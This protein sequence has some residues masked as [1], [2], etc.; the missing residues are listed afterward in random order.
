MKNEASLQTR[1]PDQ[2]LFVYQ[3]LGEQN[4]RKDPWWLAWW[5]RL[6]TPPLLA[7]R[8]TFQ[9]RDIERRARIASA[10]SLY[11]A[12]T[13]AL[14]S[15]VATFGPN[16]QI[17]NII[18]PSLIFIAISLVFNRF[19]K[20]NWAG[21][22]LVVGIA[23]SMD[24]SLW[25]APG[26][27][28][29]T[30]TQILFLLMFSDMF[31][32]SILPLKF[33]WFP[34]VVNIVYSFIVLRFAHHS[35]ALA[36]ALPLSFFPTIF[37]LCMIHLVASGVPWILVAIMRRLIEQSHNA[38]EIIKLQRSMQQQANRQL[39]EKEELEKSIQQIMMVLLRISNG[40]LTARIRPEE[41]PHLASIVGLLNNLLG[42]YE[43]AKNEGKEWETQHLQF[44]R[45]G[46]EALQTVQRLQTAMPQLSAAI[47]YAI[48]KSTPFSCEKTLTPLDCII[49]QMNGASIQPPEEGAS[50]RSYK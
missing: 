5:Y 16:K 22:L 26:G 30:D 46:K 44:Y 20:V 2:D 23:G 35:S 43:H 25:T 4:Y 12:A 45:Q 42:R 49:E 37:R 1:S 10:L 32:V 15:L 38:Q 27:L 17:F 31:F 9:E 7:P 29:P 34:A 24:W 18:L 14:A 11:Y 3:T 21:C 8:A 28:S 36:A 33:G 47:A 6:T 39:Q 19:G 13:L 50:A 40:D 41:A 48:A